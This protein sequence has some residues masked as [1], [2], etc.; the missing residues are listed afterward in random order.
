MRCCLPRQT[1]AIRRTFC[2]SP[3]RPPLPTLLL[4]SGACER[5]QPPPLDSHPE[6][7][8][9]TAAAVEALRVAT[10]GNQAVQW[11]ETLRT[12]NPHDLR[13]VHTNEHVACLEAA[14]AALR[15]FEGLPPPSAS[16]PT[17]GTGSQ[18]TTEVTWDNTA[19]ADRRPFF[20]FDTD[21]P[22]S[23]GTEDAVLAAAGAALDAV[24][25]IM[26]GQAANAFCITRPPGH[27]AEADRAM[28]FCFV[29]NA[30]LAAAHALETCA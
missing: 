11:E 18:E 10:A 27:H 24:D 6:S 22:A 9:R 1:R 16:A 3:P 28:G 19:T 7:A 26:G 2:A 17:F 14:F 12:A 8:A 29:N 21:T 20:Y 15:R 30:A 5:H 13:R 25:A 23:V 4:R